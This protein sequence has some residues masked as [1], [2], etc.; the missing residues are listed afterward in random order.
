LN[1]RLTG[2]LRGSVSDLL[3]V[4]GQ[5]RKVIAVQRRIPLSEAEREAL[6][7]ALADTERALA[8]IAEL[9]GV[10]YGP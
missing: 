6:E 7:S 5:L 3:G 2:A 4:R 8:A 10:R 1:T 9:A